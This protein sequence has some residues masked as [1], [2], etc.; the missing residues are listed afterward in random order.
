MDCREI[1]NN[2]NIN[3]EQNKEEN[4]KDIKEI[5]NSKINIT[6]VNIDKRQSQCFA[7]IFHN[8]MEIKLN[9]KK[10]FFSL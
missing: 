7:L 9:F 2:K 6:D 4:N 5:T 10:K 8:F 3:K 1:N